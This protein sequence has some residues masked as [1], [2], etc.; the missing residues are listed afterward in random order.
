[1]NAIKIFPAASLINF[2]LVPLAYRP[3]FVQALTLFWN[4]Y[5]AYRTQHSKNAK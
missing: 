5:L 1:M 4:T 2:Y 3:F